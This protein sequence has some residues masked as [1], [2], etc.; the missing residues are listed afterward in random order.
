MDWKVQLVPFH[1]FPLNYLQR[2]QVPW[3]QGMKSWGFLPLPSAFWSGSLPS[4]LPCSKHYESVDV[5]TFDISY[6]PSFIQAVLYSQSI[7]CTNFIR[8]KPHYSP[9][10]YSAVLDLLQFPRD[11]SRL[12]TLLYTWGCL[13]TC[14]MWEHMHLLYH[15]Q[16]HI[17][18]HTIMLTPDKHS[19][20]FG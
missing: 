4:A 12:I 17:H 9:P 10:S 3:E 14:L 13:G 5:V 20:K 6:F 2:L 18:I 1:L 15:V 11:L 8:C 7:Y 19:M 16:K